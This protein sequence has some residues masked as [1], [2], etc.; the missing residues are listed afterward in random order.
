MDGTINPWRERTGSE[1]RIDFDGPDHSTSTGAAALARRLTAFWAAK[2]EPCEYEA[3]Y[4]MPGEDGRSVWGVRIKKPI[5]VVVP[6]I[7]K[8]PAPPTEL[9]SDNAAPEV[10]QFCIDILKERHPGIRFEDIDGT[11]R[12]VRTDKVAYDARKDC[13]CAIKSKYGFGPARIARL[14]G[15]D[16]SSVTYATSEK[17]RANKRRRDLAKAGK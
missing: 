9:P 8:E 2:G 11:E 7:V 4:V 15:I 12:G 3:H 5:V 16:E 14:F 6:E 17:V 10:V 13:I 1:S